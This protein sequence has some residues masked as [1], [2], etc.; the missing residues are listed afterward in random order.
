MQLT[1]HWAQ[2]M[3][4]VARELLKKELVSL[5]KDEVTFLET[6]ALR[7]RSVASPWDWRQPSCCNG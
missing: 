2:A 4:H 6:L 1:F 3:A 5:M 7:T